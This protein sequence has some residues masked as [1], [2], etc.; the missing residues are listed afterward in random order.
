VFDKSTTTSSRTSVSILRHHLEPYRGPYVAPA[1]KRFHHQHRTVS[2]QYHK[3]TYPDAY[4]HHSFGIR[5]LPTGS[6]IHRRCGDLT[7]QAKFGTNP[8]SL[9][10]CEQLQS[11]ERVKAERRINRHVEYNYIVGSEWSMPPALLRC[12]KVRPGWL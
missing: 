6:I 9:P 1:V 8:E 7:Y 10:C 4:I 2:Y 3:S 11:S 5:S 12:L